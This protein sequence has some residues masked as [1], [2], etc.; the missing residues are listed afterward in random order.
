MECPKC[1]HKIEIYPIELY[2]ASDDSFISC[3]KDCPNCKAE[4]TF[5]WD[6]NGT[7]VEEN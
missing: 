6:F 4:L 7:F 3:S 5:Y 1:K 2:L